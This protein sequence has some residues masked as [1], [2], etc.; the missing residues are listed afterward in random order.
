MTPHDLIAQL[1]ADPKIYKARLEEHKKLIQEHDQKLAKLRDEDKRL[2]AV[3]R[4]SV[5]QHAKAKGL[6]E[7]AEKQRKANEAKESEL[8]AREIDV[9]KRED[10]HRVASE[11]K[12][13]DLKAREA[14]VA[15][16]EAAIK[17]TESRLAMLRKDL[18]NL[19]ASIKAREAKARDFARSLM[20]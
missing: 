6:T 18:E 3:H 15:K 16:R 2:E 10:D 1:L 8:R 13:A 7:A 19:T 12:D 4:D 14:D 5:E 17:P 11:K 20:G 9:R